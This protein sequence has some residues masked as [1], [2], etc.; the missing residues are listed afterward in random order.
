[1]AGGLATH[2]WGVQCEDVAGARGAATRALK[3]TR[4]GSTDKAPRYVFNRDENARHKWRDILT[5]ATGVYGAGVGAHVGF[6]VHDELLSVTEQEC[7]ALGMVVS[8]YKRYKALSK[9]HNEVTG[10]WTVK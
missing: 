2:C 7:L 4:A 5:H 8:D 3:H 10:Q 6:G 1:V 9:A